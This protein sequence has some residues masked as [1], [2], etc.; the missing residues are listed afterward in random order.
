MVDG[1]SLAELT[2]IEELIG[3]LVNKRQLISD[4][5]LLILMNLVTNPDIISVYRQNSLKLFSFLVK[6]KRQFLDDNLQEILKLA[7]GPIGQ[8][9]LDNFISVLERSC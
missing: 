4:N 6:E 1:L 8:V 5:I 2:C 7:F 9:T 3:L